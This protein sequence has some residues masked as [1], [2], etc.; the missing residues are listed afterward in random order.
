LN[1]DMATRTGGRMAKLATDVR[2]RLLSAVA[3]MQNALLHE[4]L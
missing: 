2:L 4:H 3:A 1:G